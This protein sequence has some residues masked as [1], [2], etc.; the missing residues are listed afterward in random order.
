MVHWSSYL[1]KYPSWN[2]ILAYSADRCTDVTLP[3]V[4]VL[5]A[6]C[7]GRILLWCTTSNVWNAQIIYAVVVA[8]EYSRDIIFRF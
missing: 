6:C 2:D 1:Y 4:R 7:Q 3:G 8:A 5:P